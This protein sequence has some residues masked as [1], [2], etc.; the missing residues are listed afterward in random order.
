MTVQP[1]PARYTAA[2]LDGCLVISMPA[3]RDWIMIVS[4]SFFLL[5]WLPVEA[6]ALSVFVGSLLRGG[7]GLAWSTLATIEPFLLIWLSIWTIGGLFN[8]YGWLWHVTGRELI[9]V[10]REGIQLSRQV[11][12][13]GRAQTYLTEHITDL[14]VSPWPFAGG[15]GPRRS[16]QPFGSMGALAFDYGARTIRFA[17]TNEAEAK[18][19][20]KE[21]QRRYARYR[22]A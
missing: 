8:F 15:V 21:I 4:L 5:V 16:R 6:I 12:G 22:P 14:R 1:F 13:R 19:I 3:R 10:S 17:D 2:D 9:E 7:P 20:L 11:L 18:Q